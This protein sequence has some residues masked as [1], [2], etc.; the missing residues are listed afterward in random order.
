MFPSF[1]GSPATPRSLCGAAF[2]YSSFRVVVRT[3][4]RLYCVP[5]SPFVGGAALGGP[6]FLSFFG[7]V[8][9]SRP[10]GVALRFPP[11]SMGCCCS[12]LPSIRVVLL[13]LLLVVRCCVPHAPS[14]CGAALP[15]GWCCFHLHLLLLGRVD[16]PPPFL[17][18]AVFLTSCGWSC[19][20]HLPCGWCFPFSSSS[21]WCCRSFFSS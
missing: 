1:V 16:W 9:L 18:G 13:G 2:P 19:F 6:T 5:S 12:F 15:C 10:F 20:F 11:P 14:A 8:L 3:P 17:R 7:V 4:F 21:E